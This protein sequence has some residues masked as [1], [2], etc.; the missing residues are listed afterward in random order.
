MVRTGMD[1][2]NELR[3]RRRAFSTQRFPFGNYREDAVYFSEMNS[4]FLLTF[5]NNDSPTWSYTISLG[6]NQMRQENRYMQTMAPQLLIPEIYNFTNTAVNL[7]INQNNSEKR[8]NSL[9]IWICPDR[10]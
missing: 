2:Y 8:I 5:S 1:Y 7:Q 6:G 9:S 10:V 4:D 3:E